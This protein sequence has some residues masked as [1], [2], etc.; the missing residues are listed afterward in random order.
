MS[1]SLPPS[2]F[3]PRCYPRRRSCWG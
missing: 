1:S 3:W 2:S